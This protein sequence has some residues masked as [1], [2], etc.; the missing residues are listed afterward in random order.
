MKDC[1]ARAAG[2]TGPWL[3][4]DRTLVRYSFLMVVHFAW[5]DEL[6]L[7]SIL[8]SY[9]DRSCPFPSLCACINMEEV[10][11]LLITRTVSHTRCT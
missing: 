1:H 4:V 6:S 7:Q 8:S 5:S 9:G 11:A 3:V 10:D 2:R